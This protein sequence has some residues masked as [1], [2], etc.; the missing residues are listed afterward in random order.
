MTTQFTSFLAVI[1]YIMK[2]HLKRLLTAVERE[3]KEA[4][5]AHWTM[6]HKKKCS[7]TSGPSGLPHFAVD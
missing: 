5:I 1:G 7:T 3:L 6:A 4:A 2:G